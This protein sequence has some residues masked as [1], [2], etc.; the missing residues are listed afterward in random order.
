M[1]NC[2]EYYNKYQLNKFTKDSIPFYNL[3]NKKFLC[4]VVDIYDGDTCTIIFK[5]NRK[6]QKYKVRMN[7]YD[8]PEMKPNKNIKN[9]STIIKN[10]KNAKLALSNMILNKIVT[11]ECGPWD[12]YG[13]LLGTIYIKY[14]NKQLNINK[15]MI[16][17]NYGYVY[18]GGKK[19]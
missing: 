15:W 8:S 9:R 17:N 6:F 10:A 16:E 19:K 7:G 5:N 1:G 3:N 11:I 14:N 13:R 18:N 12:K 4:K 2:I